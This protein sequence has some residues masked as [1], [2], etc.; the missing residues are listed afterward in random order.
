MV[1]G[2]SSR[3]SLALSCAAMWVVFSGDCISGTLYLRASSRNSGRKEKSRVIMIALG[4]RDKKPSRLLRRR[5]G[6]SVSR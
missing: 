3:L 4:P 5:S 6:G 1:R 2:A